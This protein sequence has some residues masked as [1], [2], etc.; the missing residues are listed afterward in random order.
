MG[1]RPSTFNGV[2]ADAHQALQIVDAWKKGQSCVT[3]AKAIRQPNARP[4]V[5]SD[6]TSF[7]NMP[8]Y[9]EEVCT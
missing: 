6:P 3:E 1:P 5:R 9:T 2:Q 7:A 8:V 4:Q